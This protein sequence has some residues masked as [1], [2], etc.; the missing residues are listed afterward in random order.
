MDDH[1]GLR[2][3]GC[4]PQA[5]APPLDL[6]GEEVDISER[7]LV[8]DRIHIGKQRLSITYR[9]SHTAHF[10]QYNKILCIEWLRIKKTHEG[11]LCLTTKADKTYIRI[12]NKSRFHAKNTSIVSISE[13]GP[14]IEK[15]MMD[16]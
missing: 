8:T 16:N 12:D 10:I 14:P 15:A 5:S 6:V 7:I 11:V 9:G 4:V 1:D 3:A 13:L 2:D